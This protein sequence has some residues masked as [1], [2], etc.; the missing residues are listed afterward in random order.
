[1]SESD[2]EKDHKITMTEVPDL[3]PDE[4]KAEKEN[5]KRLSRIKFSRGKP[6]KDKLQKD[7]EVMEEYINMMRD[8]HQKAQKIRKLFPV[9]KTKVF[10]YLRI[11]LVKNDNHQIYKKYKITSELRDFFDVENFYYDRPLMVRMFVKYIKDNKLQIPEDK[12][13]FKLSPALGK[14]FGE[15]QDKVLRFCDLQKYISRFIIKESKNAD[16][17]LDEVPDEVP[18]AAGIDGDSSASEEEKD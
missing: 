2:D 15:E 4:L 3:S 7:F 13:K 1:M 8:H 17:E 11:N 16:L 6:S 5:A 9:L 14:L 10:R 18:E 12:R